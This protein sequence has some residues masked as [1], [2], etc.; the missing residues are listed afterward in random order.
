VVVLLVAM[1]VNGVAIE[2]F[3]VAWDL[4]LQENVPQD[5]LARVY[6]YDALGSFLALPLGEMLAGPLA[7]RFGTRT[8]LLCGTALVA[9]V[10]VAA[11]GSRQ[12]RELTTTSVPTPKAGSPEPDSSPGPESQPERA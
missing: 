8:T 7:E 11:L 1:F 12:V 2:Q 4:S 10:T 3:G 5:K 9:L 6:S